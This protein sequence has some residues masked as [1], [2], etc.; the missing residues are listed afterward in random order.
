[1]R[2]SYDARSSTLAFKAI[3]SFA[4]E[5]VVQFFNTSF[6]ELA[7]GFSIP[8]R[9]RILQY[10]NARNN[11]FVGYHHG[12]IK[13]PDLEL[14]LRDSSGNWASMLALEVGYSVP[15]EELVDDA[16]F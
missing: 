2:F 14:V 7:F 11:G 1:M 15:Y 5:A 8:L 6:I 4:H 13:V 12:S 3:T 16:R 10:M 9:K